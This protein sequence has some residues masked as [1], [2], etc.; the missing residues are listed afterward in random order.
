MRFAKRRTFEEAIA[1]CRQEGTSIYVA[2]EEKDGCEYNFQPNG[3]CDRISEFC[4]VCSKDGRHPNRIPRED[5]ICPS[6]HRDY[7]PRLA[8]YKGP[9]SAERVY[10]HLDAA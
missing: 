5:H 9:Q 8:A 10:V 3:S 7:S 2:I 1:L 4:P 6:C